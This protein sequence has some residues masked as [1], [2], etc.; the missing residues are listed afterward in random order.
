MS[1]MRLAFI[2]ALVIGIPAM[3]YTN[4]AQAQA[5]QDI[6]VL[7]VYT[8]AFGAAVQEPT[9]T[10]WI[11]EGITLSNQVWPNNELPF[12]LRLVGMYQTDYV[13]ST[14]P[15]SGILTLAHLQ[16]P[17]DGRGDD[18][19][20]VRDQVGADIVIIVGGANLALCGAAFTDSV[21][22]PEQ[23]YAIVRSDC[24]KTP[25]V[26]LHEVGHLMGLSHNVESQP[27]ALFNTGHGYQDP[28][29]RFS[30]VMCANNPT[31]TIPYFSSATRLYN[32]LP[33]GNAYKADSEALL[34]LHGPIVANY[35]PSKIPPG[36]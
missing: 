36:C 14:A 10:T 4:W 19:A 23:A 17:S 16:N 35:R 31:G 22:A 25:Y 26:L 5:I 18:V 24:Y 2:V 20:M 28:L 11:T 6:D 34:R 15:G 32:G 3:I 27:S 1:E 30:T 8:A 7:V 33:L 9:R 21:P 29:R 12:R 13:E